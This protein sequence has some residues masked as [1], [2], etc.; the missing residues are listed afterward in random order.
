[1]PE[2]LLESEL[3]GIERGVATGVEARR[4]KFELA[5]TGTLFLDE[6]G[7][8][9]A[10]V[11]VKLLRA[12]QEREIV[13]V[14]G[15]R[16]TP[17]DVRLVAA[18][19]HDLDA[20]V[21]AGTFREDLYYRLNVVDV[22]IPPLR[23]RREEVP[24]LVDIFLH[25]Y[26]I[27]YGKPARKASAALS[28]AME[29]YPFPGNNRELENL[30]KRIVVLGS[31][32]MV[33]AELLGGDRMRGATDRLQIVIDELA[34]TAGQVPLKEV[35][36]RAAQEAERATIDRILHR[37]HWNRKA[38]ARELGVSYKTLLQKIRDCGLEEA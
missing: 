20:L 3:F 28:R 10:T 7:D 18:T 24:V 33:L 22:R 26:S 35:G 9:D 8:L 19:H 23:E 14:G 36:R 32:D 38:A 17:V 34:A 5:H 37:T 30:I 12:L 2:S 21:A 16:P 6:I 29:R 31:E 4:G 1:M 13:R 27:K 11:Q 25:R 15:D